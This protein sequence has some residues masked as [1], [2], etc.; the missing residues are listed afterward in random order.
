MLMILSCAQGQPTKPT[1]IPAGS[2]R[3]GRELRRFTLATNSV[4]FGLAVADCVEVLA[5]RFP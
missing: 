1:A 2:E 5:A 4:A 3:G